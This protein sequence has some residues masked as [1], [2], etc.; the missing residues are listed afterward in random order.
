MPPVTIETIVMAMSILVG[1]RVNLHAWKLMGWNPSY[2]S[3]SIEACVHLLVHKEKDV[4]IHFAPLTAA[5]ETADL[6]FKKWVEP[7]GQP[8]HVRQ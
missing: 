2:K 3:H 5:F 6:E 8:Q 4:A 1:G 7:A